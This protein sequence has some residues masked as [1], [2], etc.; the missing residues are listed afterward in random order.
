MIVR[1]WMSRDVISIDAG[2]SVTAAAAAT[3]VAM[4]TPVPRVRLS[5]SLREL[6]ASVPGWLV[7]QIPIGT[8][9]SEEAAFRAALRVAGADAF[10]PAGGRLLQ[11]GAFGLSH[12]ADAR[13][14][15]APVV[16][17][18]L[19]TGVAGWFFGWLA[20]RSGSLAAPMLVHLATNEAGAIAAVAV[21]RRS[22]G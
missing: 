10:G 11:A 14:T 5:M 15:G 18:V 22:A 16:P 1:M 20:D 19:V 7:W 17:T 13:A 4:T 21:Q 3:A 9:W 12:V 6:P 2:E 8:V